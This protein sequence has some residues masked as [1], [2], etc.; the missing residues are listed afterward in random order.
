[1]FIN[2]YSY[3]NNYMHTYTYIYIYTYIHIVCIYVYTHI[4]IYIYICISHAAPGARRRPGRRAPRSSRCGPGEGGCG[5]RGRCPVGGFKASAA[6]GQFQTCGLTVACQSMTKRKQGEG[7]QQGSGIPSKHLFP[8][9][10]LPLT[11][12]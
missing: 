11:L 6:Q 2:V 5:P 8:I 10:P 1:M 9:D 12:T 4:C 7:V 3:I